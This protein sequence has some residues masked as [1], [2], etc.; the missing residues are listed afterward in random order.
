MGAFYSTATVPV[1]TGRKK[2]SVVRDAIIESSRNKSL[3]RPALKFDSLDSFEF[4][5][6]GKLFTYNP[7]TFWRI[8]SVWLIEKCSPELSVLSLESF[9]T[10]KFIINPIGS[11]VLRIHVTVVASTWDNE[12]EFHVTIEKIYKTKRGI[13]VSVVCTDFYRIVSSSN[14]IVDVISKSSRPKCEK[15]SVVCNKISR[16]HAKLFAEL[17]DFKS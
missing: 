16:H 6:E 7:T 4:V 13:N 10:R 2:Y 5:K 3:N 8:G 11:I 14:K 12:G 1:T 15:E 9:A 17:I